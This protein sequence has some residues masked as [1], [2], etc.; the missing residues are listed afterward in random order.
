MIRALL[1]WIAGL[2]TVVPYSV[3]YLLVRAERDQYAAL[4]TFVLFWVFGYWGVVGPILAAIKARA[5]FRAIED[6]R[7]QEQLAEVLRSSASRDVAIDFIASEHRI[8]RFLA[9]TIYR[10]VAARVTVAMD[11]RRGTTEGGRPGAQD[12]IS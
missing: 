6:S 2:L 7:T 11:S 8:P 12:R 4:I 1:V 5:V 9:E 10:R 3:Y